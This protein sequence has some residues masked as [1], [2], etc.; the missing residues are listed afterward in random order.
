MQEVRQ[1]LEELNRDELLRITQN[2]LKRTRELQ[3]FKSEEAE[4]EKVIKALKKPSYKIA[5]VANMSAGKSTF[6]NALLGCEILPTANAATTDCATEIYH[7]HKRDIKA[8]VYFADDKE[9]VVLKGKN[10]IQDIQEYA[11][12]DEDCKDDKYKNVEK[13]KLYH[14]FAYVK[15]DNEEYEVVFIDT[16]GPNSTGENYKEKHQNQTREVLRNSDMALFLFNCRQVDANLQSDEQGLWNAIKTKK[17][18]D[19]NFEVYF[20]VNKIDGVFGDNFKHI[21]KNNKQEIFEEYKKNWYKTE[22]EFLEKIKNA[23]IK[24]GIKKPKVYGISALNAYRLRSEDL[25]PDDEDEL[26]LLKNKFLRRFNEN[27]LENELIKYCGVDKLEDDLNEYINNQI[28]QKLKT[29]TVQTILNSVNKILDELENKVNKLSDEN[30]AKIQFQINE[31]EEYIQKE[32]PLLEEK[33]R[34]EIVDLNKKFENSIKSKINQNIEKHFISNVKKITLITT[35]FMVNRIRE[36]GDDKTAYK[37]ALKDYMEYSINNTTRVIDNRYNLNKEDLEKSTNYCI[38]SQ[39]N[40]YQNAYLDTISSIKNMFKDFANH[41][42][43]IIKKYKKILEDNINKNLNFTPKRVELSKL[44][45]N[46]L[47]SLNSLNLSKSVSHK[48]QN[49]IYRSN[50]KWWNPFS[51][52][53][54]DTKVQDAKNEFILSIQKL[55]DDFNADI[56]KYANDIQ[57]QEETKCLTIIRNYKNDGDNVFYEFICD[58]KEQIA[59]LQN[60]LNDIEKSIKINQD[61]IKAF[62]DILKG[63]NNE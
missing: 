46:G 23:A 53:S 19:D 18:E 45:I 22:N 25:N 10:E 11:K 38:K 35:A 34:K 49:A 12:K 2:L 56:K 42:D 54:E 9:M 62:E 17:E 61:T 16:P 58:K 31:A 51:W 14:P 30:K 15:N 48:K 63:E 29:I 50:V 1:R 26:N 20:V 36:Y 27:E 60:S 6:L 44:D 33:F 43:E 57:T 52:F 4:F 21:N 55:Y 47:N 5:V 59:G 39:F 13:I 7:C 3:G 32:S 37:M 41:N 40:T 24:H 28:L 8:E